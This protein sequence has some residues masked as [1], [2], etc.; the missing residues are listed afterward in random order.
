[1]ETKTRSKESVLALGLF[2]GATD[3][4]MGE[5]GFYG[6]G[7]EEKQGDTSE[8]PIGVDEQL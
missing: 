4:P 3:R 8:K 1:M 5:S 7:F 2:F 6:H